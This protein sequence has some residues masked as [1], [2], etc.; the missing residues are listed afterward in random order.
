[1]SKEKLSQTFRKPGEIFL[2]SRLKK[3]LQEHL[4]P[5]QQKYI[6]MRESSRLLHSNV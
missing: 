1:M 3:T 5:Q 4:A 6:K 2:K